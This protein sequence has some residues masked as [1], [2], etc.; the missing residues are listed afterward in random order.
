[1]KCVAY[2]LLLIMSVGIVSCEED[3][4]PGERR[5]VIGNVKSAPYELLVVC[6][7]SWY[8]SD[9]G[10]KFHDMVNTYMLGMPQNEPIFKVICINTGTFSKT[11]MTFGCIIFVNIDRKYTKPE[12]IKQRNMYAMPQMVVTL[13]SPDSK[14][15]DELVDEHGSEIVDLMESNEIKRAM[16]LLKKS[17]S[18]IVSQYAEKKFGC[19]W[20]MP[21]MIT[22]IKD[23]K[24]FFWASSG[25]N[26]YNACMYSYPWTSGST[27]TKEYFIEKRDSF[28][29]KNIEGEEWGQY[30]TTNASSVVSK[31]RM[32]D[33]HYV[34]EVHGIWEMENDLMAGPFVSYVQLDSLNQRII[35]TEGFVYLPNKEKKKMVHSLE[36]G[37]RTLKMGIGP[38]EN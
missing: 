29:R 35:V 12:Y 25:D 26:V 22:L 6:D 37:L 24:D 10:K 32:L 14:G 19:E 38:K 28:M 4:K 27:F 23:G 36:A 2:I 16:N 18:R 7:K 5:K 17:H 21:D 31:E 33:G 13:N 34:Q 3:V 8:K 9:S 1:M 20:L 30:V 15:I 11:F